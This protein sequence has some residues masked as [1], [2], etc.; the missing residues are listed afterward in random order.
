MLVRIAL[1]ADTNE[2]I[3]VQ[4]PDGTMLSAYANRFGKKPSITVT[5]IHQDKSTELLC[6]AEYD[7]Y[8]DPPEGKQ[9]KIGA[10]THGS[11]DPAYRE[12]FF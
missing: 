1:R 6:Y 11:E 2:E 4:L 3:R 12:C 5:L 10:F 9:L 7:G 8:S